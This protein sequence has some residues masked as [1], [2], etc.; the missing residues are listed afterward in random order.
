MASITLL[1]YGAQS[2]SGTSTPVDVSAAAL[3]RLDV[4]ATADLGKAPD[5]DVWIET[6][7]TSSGPWL[8]LNHIRYGALQPPTS[9]YAWQ[10]STRVLIGSADAF[11]RVR[12][13]AR[14]T[15]NSPDSNPQL[16]LGVTGTAP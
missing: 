9:P 16:L 13:S 5:L 11:C 4:R 15:R 1:T 6:G 14:A 10:D 3:L 2:A 12:W 7:P 8:E